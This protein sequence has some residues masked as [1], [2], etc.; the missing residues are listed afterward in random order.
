MISLNRVLSAAGATLVLALGSACTTG[1]FGNILGGVLGGGTTS[2]SGYVQG[3]DA[4]NQVITIQQQNGQTIQAT[5]DNNTQIVYGNQNYPATALRYGDQI[6]AQLQSTNGGYYL[7]SAQVLQSGSNSTYGYPNGTY[8]NGTYPSG[9]YPPGRY[10]TGSASVQQFV[11]SV[12]Q[13]DRGNGW[14]TLNTNGGYFTVTMPYNA[15]SRDQQR[16]QNLRAGDYVSIYGMLVNSGQIQL[17]QF[18]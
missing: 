9:T 14:F 4:R 17:T 15:E 18:R 11:G 5:Y 3:I 10:P 16:F 6:S 13:I 1:Q 2:A 8:P 7:A 12:R